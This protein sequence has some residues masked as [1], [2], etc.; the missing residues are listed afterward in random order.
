[1]LRAVI[2]DMDGL[3]IDSE[4]LWV[5]AEKE[6][7]AS[8][9]VVLTEEDCARTKGLRI[10]DVVRHWQEHRGFSAAAADASPAMVEA[11]IIT[12]LT[13]LISAEGVARPGIATALASARAN[14]RAIALASSSPTAVIEAAL[15][16]LGLRRAFD[17]VQ[18]A[19]AEPLGK[20]HPGVFLRTAD[21][22]GVSARECVVLEDSMT[23]VIAAKAARMACIAVPVDHPDH[24]ARFALA[25]AVVGTLE[26]VT[27]ELL[28]HTLSLV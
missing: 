10:D 13:R 23:G 12:R 4:P 7:F 17:V 14:G 28:E 5:R 21:R 8:V 18:S 20:P 3:L 22:L 6:I 19:E 1:M 25:D 16:R 2:F 27:T 11:R 9:G 26:D 15:D 24:E